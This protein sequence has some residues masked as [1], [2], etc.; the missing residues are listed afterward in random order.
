MNKL[1][2]LFF[3]CIVILGSCKAPG[4]T[5][6]VSTAFINANMLHGLAGS[7][8]N[9]ELEGLTKN[10]TAGVH[11]YSCSE[12]IQHKIDATGQALSH[13]EQLPEKEDAKPLLDA[14]KAV[15]RYAL[16]MLT[17]D[18]KQLAQLYDSKADTG[19]IREFARSI[20]QKHETT[21]ETLYARLG[22]KGMEYAQNNKVKVLNVQ[23]SPSH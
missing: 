7:M 16:Q 21:F 18:Y 6:Y 10:N 1:K 5:K 8:M 23:T 3:C 15:F 13:I 2:H 19:R 9:N 11:Q 14:S 4:P 17:T 20:Q 12:Y 22:D